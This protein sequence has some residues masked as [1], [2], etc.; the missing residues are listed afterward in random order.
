MTTEDDLE[1]QR[2]ICEARG[3]LRDGYTTRAKVDEL[4][5]RIARH[6][7][8]QLAGELREEMRRQWAIRDKWIGDQ[9]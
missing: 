7:G 5:V 2:R 9:S 8:E 1:R 4:M 3:W 6:R